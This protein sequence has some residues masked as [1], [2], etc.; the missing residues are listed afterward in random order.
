MGQGYWTVDHFLDELD[1]LISGLGIAG[2]YDLL[3]QSFGACLAAEHAA[4]RPAGMGALV[5]AN[6][7]A[8]SRLFADGARRL[9]EG[10]PGDA[11][12]VIA[13]HES[14]GTRDTE[15]YQAAMGV[16]A[17]EHLCRTQ[18]WPAEM[19]RSMANFGEAAEVVASVIG[20]SVF[21]FE[22]NLD[23]W[24]IIDR[25]SGIAAPTLAYRGAFDEVVEEAFAPFGRQIPNAEAHVFERSSHMPHIEEP[26]ACLAL[27]DDFLRRAAG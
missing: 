19:M 23:G 13:A 27:I 20:P 10:L 9:C 24:S 4:R 16:F 8:D 7:F 15:A 12:R 25:L 6:G 21:S 22:G 11:G 18:P 3:G 17:S 14:S 2:R 1:S 5:L 26:Q